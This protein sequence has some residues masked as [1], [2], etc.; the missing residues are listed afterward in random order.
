MRPNLSGSEQL[1]DLI[2]IRFEFGRIVRMTIYAVILIQV[3]T[4]FD[5]R[6]GVFATPLVGERELIQALI[7]TSSIPEIG[8]RATYAGVP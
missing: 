2:G 3:M 5:V 7:K 1:R 6:L 8:F 4:R